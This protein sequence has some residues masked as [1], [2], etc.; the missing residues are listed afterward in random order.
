T[1]G[2]VPDEDAAGYVPAMVDH[3]VPEVIA[4][5]VGVPGGGVE[6][7]LHPVRPGLADGFRQLPAML[8]LD[9]FQQAGQGA[10]RSLPR[11][12]AGKT[13]A[14][15][16]VQILPGLCVLL[17]RSQAEPA[18][19]LHCSPPRRKRRKRTAVLG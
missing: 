9:V 16:G 3:V 8:A 13:A 5:T 19:S 12:G 11:C 17:D 18:G 6:E 4:D 14:D 1:A 2:L 15:P 10:P 7:A